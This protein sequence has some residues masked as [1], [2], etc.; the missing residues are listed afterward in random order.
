MTSAVSDR[1][2]LSAL[3]R[4]LR[5]WPQPDAPADHWRALADEVELP[6]ADP[7]QLRRH[8]VTGSYLR[9]RPGD[10]TESRRQRHRAA[11]LADELADVAGRLASAGVE[12]A[13]LRGPAIGRFYPPGWPR[14][15]NDVD[16]VLR[17]PPDL[18]TAFDALA[19]AGWFPARPVTTRREPGVGGTWAAAALN[20]LR[21]DLDHPVY[22]D[23]TVG[24][25]AVDRCRCV[26]LPAAAWAGSGR[27]R[28]RDADVAGFGPTQLAV[29]L[30]VEWME[31]D[32]A[33]GRDLLD[34]LVL[35]DVGIGWDEVGRAIRRHGLQRGVRA[36]AALAAETGLAE[37]A[38]HLRRL[39]PATGPAGPG[40][41]QRLLTRTERL[42]RWAIRRRPVATLEV[43]E[44]MP[45]ATWYGLGLP[46]YAYPPRRD[47]RP[48]R[49]AGGAAAAGLEGYRSRVLPIA[50]EE[51]VDEVFAPPH[52][53]DPGGPLTPVELRWWQDTLT[54]QLADAAGAAPTGR[55]AALAATV[56]GDGG[57]EDTLGVR[58]AGL[59]VAAA[60][61]VD[62]RHPVTDQADRRL[63]G[64]C[65]DP[66][67]ADAVAE[68]LARLP[69]DLDVRVELPA[70]PSTAALRDAVRSSG[71]REEVLTVR[72]AADAAARRGDWSLRAAGP[73]D[74]NFVVDCL[75]I[76]VRRGLFGRAAAVDVGEWV[77]KRWPAPGSPD[78]EC[79]VAE[80]DGRP[81]GHAYA[82]IGL[83]RYSPAE[84]AHVIDVFVL[85]EARGRGCSQALTAE[86][87]RRLAARGVPDMES[88]VALSGGGDTTGLL[89]GLQKAGWRVDRAWWIR[90]AA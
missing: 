49:G 3:T 80:L 30:A 45:A 70:G 48:L 50:E 10:G 76:A 82:L 85:P 81:V 69:T 55:V 36:L 74:A 86:L 31:R 18:A 23:L 83:D 27:V 9:L 62:C 51:V 63:E 89:A 15:A 41:R 58:R 5:R 13:V 53:L 28:I 38:E 84:S 60:R 90:E 7:A 72:R 33:I 46:L 37:P 61:L 6:A 67:A 35:R 79:V 64:L 52:T 34:F 44:R 43:V 8:K 54:R 32:R 4:A 56:V 68:L 88:E 21:P 20:K 78:V 19:P 42:S 1:E 29:V 12:H 47:G 65:V 73:D 17:R 40:W 77:G 39:A 14:E 22:L 11:V 16:L 2:L 57:A 26:V 25:P 71:F 75:A 87:S 24:G 66:S 59:A